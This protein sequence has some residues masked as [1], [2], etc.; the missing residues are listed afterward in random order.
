MRCP[1]CSAAQHLRHWEEQHGFKST[2]DRFK[3]PLKKT[4]S[5][6]LVPRNRI[7][8]GSGVQ[9]PAW[10]GGSPQHWHHAGM[11]AQ[12][13]VAGE[14][15]VILE[16]P[17]AK[18]RGWEVGQQGTP[19]FPFAGPPGSSLRGAWGCCAALNI[20]WVESRWRTGGG[21]QGPGK[22]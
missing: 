17:R 19:P 13:L 15:M 2:V 21:G 1:T 4:L 22:N 12:G 3:T 14:E 18:V 9:Y 11:S 16:P 5:V 10:V 7:Q 8:P 6:R 20:P